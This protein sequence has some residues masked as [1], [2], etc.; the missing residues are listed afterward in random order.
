MATEADNGGEKRG[1]DGFIRKGD[2]G[3]R[4]MF[5]LMV[6]ENQWDLTFWKIKI[7][8]GRQGVIIYKCFGNGILVGAFSFSLLPLFEL[9]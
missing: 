8:I 9:W 4:S 2:S 1:Y 7:L 5:W 3:G 6:G